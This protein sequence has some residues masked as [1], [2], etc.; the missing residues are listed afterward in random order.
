MSV[1][2]SRAGSPNANL[3]LRSWRFVFNFPIRAKTSGSLG[4][5]RNGAF[6][7]VEFLSVTSFTSLQPNS[8]MRCQLFL[9]LLSFAAVAGAAA[10]PPPVRSFQQV[11]VDTNISIGYGIAAA[12]V[13]GDGKLDL[14][15]AD[16]ER[17]VWYENPGW[18][19]HV[20]T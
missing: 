6:F 18:Q 19:K 3:L 2:K 16:K 7:R 9:A 15:L 20:L 14:L 13:N 17:F 10:A 11:S 4:V 1:S 12:D 8:F 5:S